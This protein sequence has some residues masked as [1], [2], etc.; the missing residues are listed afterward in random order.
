MFWRIRQ[1][2]Q[3]SVINISDVVFYAMHARQEP[4]RQFNHFF[5]LFSSHPRLASFSIPKKKYIHIREAITGAYGM[6]VHMNQNYYWHGTRYLAKPPYSMR[7]IYNNLHFL[8]EHLQRTL[9]IPNVGQ[10]VQSDDYIVLANRRN[11]SRGRS[12]LN[13][14]AVLKVACFLI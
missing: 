9:H 1:H 12:V 5:P 10:Y 2:Q 6:T 14:P 3:R 8:R 11:N 13:A 7:S 4:K